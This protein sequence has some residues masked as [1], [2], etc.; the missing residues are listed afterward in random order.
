MEYIVY[1]YHNFSTKTKLT[2]FIHPRGIVYPVQIQKDK[3][4][5]FT[6]PNNKS[7]W[8]PKK[9]CEVGWHIIIHFPHIIRYPLMSMHIIDEE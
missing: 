4:P 9:S 7:E 1:A 5:V 3:L 6:D 2:L 8:F